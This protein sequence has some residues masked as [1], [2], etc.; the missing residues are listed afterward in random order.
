M[1]ISSL[2]PLL[3]A[4]ESV[5]CIWIMSALS[6]DGRARDDFD[7]AVM[8]GLRQRTALGD[9]DQVTLV[10]TQ[11]VLRVQ[12]GRPADDL[13]QQ[14]M[15]HL[16]LDQDG[17]RLV[18]LVADDA[19]LEG[20][21]LLLVVA[22]VGG[23]LLLRAEHE[24]RAGDVAPDAAQLVRLAELAGAFCMRRLNCSL[25]RSSRCCFSSSADLVFRSLVAITS[26]PGS[27]I[28]S[29][30]RAWRR[31]GGMPRVPLPRR[32]PRFHRACGPAGSERPRTRRRP[33]RRPYAL[34]WASW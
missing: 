26:P 9:T 13:A 8:L 6:S 17:D 30:P 5:L 1:H 10:R 34:R 31:P 3:S 18:H 28:G 2:A 15:L 11:V 7:H 20:A 29:A 16:A 14:A 23:P 27:R 12:L 33:C 25:R 22:H 4:A 21:R 24:L 19:T 32:Y